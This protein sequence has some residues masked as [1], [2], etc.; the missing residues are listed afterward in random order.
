MDVIHTLAQG[1]RKPNGAILTDVA[2][3][4]LYIEATLTGVAGPS[5]ERNSEESRLSITNVAQIH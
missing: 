2:G 1:R 4:L 5:D 3:A